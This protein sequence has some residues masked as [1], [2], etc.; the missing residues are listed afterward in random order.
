VSYPW[1]T[2]GPQY[3]SAAFAK[4]RDLRAEPIDQANGSKPSPLLETSPL[5]AR[6]RTRSVADSCHRRRPS[7]ICSSVTPNRCIESNGRINAILAFE[8]IPA[9]VLPEVGK[10]QRRTGGVRQ[11]LPLFVAISAHIKYKPPDRIGAA[12]AVIDHLLKGLIYRSTRWSCSKASIRSRKWRDRNS[13][14][15]NRPRQC[16]KR[17]RSWPV[18]R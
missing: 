8:K 3:R 5:C 11:E 7:W 13:V 1:P 6:L 9:N 16:H 18:L 17:S 2:N 12:S 10:L 15:G 14:P 4:Q